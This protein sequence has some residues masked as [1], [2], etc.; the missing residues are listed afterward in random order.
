MKTTIEF[1]AFGTLAL[2]LTLIF[3]PIIKKIAV[4]V[5]LVDKPHYRKVHNTPVPLVGGISIA[6]SVVLVILLSGNRL[7][8]LMEYLPIITS[9]FVLLI[10]GVIDDKN[11]V[12]AKYK[13]AIQLLLSL[14]I[15]FSGIRISSLYGLFGIYEIAVWAQYILTLI[16]IT[17]VVNAFNLMDGVDGLVGGLSVL[18]FTMF[19]LA[20]IYFNNYF[21]GKI[22][23]IFLGAIIGFLRFNLSKNKIFM[24]DSG[25]LF[26]GF[27]LVT[28]GIKFMEEQEAS[29]K[30]YTYGFLLLVSF[31]SIPVL[32]SLRVYFGRIKQGNSPFKADKSHLHHLLLTAG[33]THKKVAVSVVAFS[34]I[35][36]FIGF[37]LISYQSISIIILLMMIV[38]WGIVRLLLMIKS[39]HEWRATLKKLEHR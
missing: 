2:L 29:Q 18:G 3:I 32:D 25:S 8:F 11:D 31:F 1:L 33:L 19:L 27:V 34:M 10:V 5:N 13:L 9:G 30:G 35:L 21:L 38:F 17:G 6:F 4:K 37:G 15:A 16:V 12:S 26:L 7:P 22:S 28:L 36:F 20:S 39:L 14:I 24:G 23:V